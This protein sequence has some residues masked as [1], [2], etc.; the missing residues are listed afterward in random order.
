MGNR[1]ALFTIVIAVIFISAGCVSNTSA[2]SKSTP[3]ESTALT[4][5]NLNNVIITL[6]DLPSGFEEETPSAAFGA[7]YGIGNHV[8]GIDY[9]MSKFQFTDQNQNNMVN[10][11]SSGN[12]WIILNTV[13]Y[14][15]DEKTAHDAFLGYVDAAGSP[16]AALKSTG[17][18]LLSVQ[19]ETSTAL[20][21]ESKLFHSEYLRQSSDGTTQITERQVAIISRKG[22]FVWTTYT[23]SYSKFPDGSDIPY[24]PH[25]QETE[26]LTSI[27][28]QRLIT[29]L[30]K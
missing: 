22:N 24:E 21:D 5:V 1:F 7:T 27:M 20:G 11:I 13:E 19:E 18:T 6:N 9:A 17:S 10:L 25:K 12:P 2:N 4:K 8:L 15:A 30:N 3:N 16:G 29:E 14:M 23:T 26:R 28:E